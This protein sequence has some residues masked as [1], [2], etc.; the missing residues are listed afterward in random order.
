LIATEAAADEQKLASATVST[1]RKLQR[2]VAVRDRPQV[3]QVV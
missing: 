1:A 2:R 3:I